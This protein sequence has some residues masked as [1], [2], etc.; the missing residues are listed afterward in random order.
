M[1]SPTCSVFIC[2]FILGMLSVNQVISQTPHKPAFKAGSWISTGGPI[3]GLGYD[4]R[5]SYE[6]LDLWDVTDAWGGIFLSGDR[7]IHWEAVNQGIDTRKGND[8]VP[9]FC[10]AVDPHNSN[11]VWIGTEQFG[12]IYKSENGGASWIEKSEGITDTLMPLT[13]RGITIDPVD[14]DIMFAM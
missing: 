12:K 4:V 3:G 13:F 6:N 8:G 5:H 14:P 11:N 9:V 10:V 2:L 1:K 7:G